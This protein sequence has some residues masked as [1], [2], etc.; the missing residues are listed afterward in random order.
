M[1]PRTAVHIITYDLDGN[2]NSDK[3]AENLF[4]FETKNAF[5]PKCITQEF[6][7]HNIQYQEWVYLRCP[8]SKGTEILAPFFSE[9]Q[10]DP[11]SGYQ[12][13][14]QYVF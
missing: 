1:G 12:L 14:L 8:A 13:R 9:F 6:K 5:W 10:V 2:L 11:K 7:T 3:Y 4:W